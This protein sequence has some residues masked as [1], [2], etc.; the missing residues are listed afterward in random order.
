MNSTGTNSHV[1]THFIS[2][3]TWGNSFSRHNP[4]F[5]NFVWLQFCLMAP[6]FSFV[7]LPAGLCPGWTGEYCGGLLWN[8]SRSHQVRFILK[9]C[10]VQIW[11]SIVLEVYSSCPFSP[12]RAIAGA[13]RPCKPRVPAAD[14]YQGYLLLSGIKDCIKHILDTIFLFLIKSQNCGSVEDALTK[15]ISIFTCDLFNSSKYLKV[16]V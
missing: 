9:N 12:Y 11:W 10:F 7:T 5:I 2:L 6:I 4:D 15:E 16:I 3:H 14:I 1:H 13:V 8:N